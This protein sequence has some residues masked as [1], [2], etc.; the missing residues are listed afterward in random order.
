MYEKVGKQFEHWIKDVNDEMKAENLPL[1]VHNLTTV[2]TVIF[3]QPGRYHW[4]FQYYLRDEGIALSWVGT[5]RLLVSLD[6]VENDFELLKKKLVN[7]AKRMRDDGWWYL[8]TPDKPI[9]AQSISAAMGKE[10]AYNTVMKTV[11][12]GLLAD[13]LQAVLHGSGVLADFV[14]VSL[15]RL[16]SAKK[17]FPS[18]KTVAPTER[19]PRDLFGTTSIAKKF[20]DFE[21]L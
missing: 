12:E 5:G 8:G 2:W 13:M 6:F 9:T 14:K 18:V 17:S 1:S 20:V 15:S 4:M 3:N 19:S 10:M 7:A 11:R 21:E 16:N